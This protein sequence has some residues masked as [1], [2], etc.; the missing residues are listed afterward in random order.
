MTTYDK[1]A[2]EKL[3]NFDNAFSS[4]G[5]EVPY[6]KNII[7][8]IL[9][10]NPNELLNIGC[11]NGDYEA[12]LRAR[13]YLNP[14]TAFDVTPSCVTRAKARELSNVDF[15]V[16]NAVEPLQYKDKQFSTVLFLNVLMHLPQPHQ[17]ILKEAFRV[18]K[19]NVIISNYGSLNDSYGKHGDFLNYFISKQDMLDMIPLGWKLKDIKEYQ[20]PAGDFVFQYLFETD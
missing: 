2:W 12:E 10:L 9:E 4:Y 18:S 13:N 5:F 17:P 7:N 16:G 3:G 11:C 6:R 19:Q 20:N 1:I 8:W 15:S 14:I